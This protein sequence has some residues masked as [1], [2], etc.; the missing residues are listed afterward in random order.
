[1]TTLLPLLSLGKEDPIATL[2]SVS[3]IFLISG[4]LLA[5][6]CAFI[7]Q[8]VEQRLCG[9]KDHQNPPNLKPEPPTFKSQTLN[10]QSVNSKPLGCDDD[11]NVVS[12]SSVEP[13]NI[14]APETLRPR[15]RSVT[16]VSEHDPRPHDITEETS[17]SPENHETT[18]PPL[19]SNPSSPPKSSITTTRPSHATQHPRL[20][21]PQTSPLDDSS[22]PTTS[23]SC[24]HSH[25]PLGI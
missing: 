3:Y 25:T 11:N 6:F 13:C 23:K 2:V 12:A 7:P 5:Y 10:I 22:S 24:T 14:I 9:P 18:I 4:F 1:M 17:E 15:T 8:D 21:Y 19:I 20:R 16:S